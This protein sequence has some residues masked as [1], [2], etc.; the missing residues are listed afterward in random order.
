M[1]SLAYVYLPKAFMYKTTVKMKGGTRFVSLSQAD[2]GALSSHVNLPRHNP[3]ANVCSDEEWSSV[4]ANVDQIIVDN[5]VMNDPSFTVLDLSRFSKLKQLEIGS[6]CFMHVTTVKL[7]GLS[8]LER[9]RIGENSFTK[10]KNS[11]GKGSNHQFYLKD[12]PKL[13]SLRVGAFSFSD[14][15]VCEIENCGLYWIY[16]NQFAFYYSSMDVKSET[17]FD[18]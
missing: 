16:M 17:A 7:I 13:Y 15:S 3:D 5:G 2:L 6:D 10:Y 9:V 4:D 18:E 12:C 14:Y 8:E 11:I 1:P